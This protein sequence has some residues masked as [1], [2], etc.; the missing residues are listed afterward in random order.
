MNTIDHGFN[1]NPV[2]AD[3]DESSRGLEILA[4]SGDNHVYA[5]RVDGTPV[6]GWPVFLRDPSKVASVNPQTHKLVYAG[7]ADAY[8]GSKVLVSPSVGDVD[9]DGDLEVVAAVNEEYAEEP[10]ASRAR[11]QMGPILGAITDVGN[12]RVYVI[13]AKGSDAGPSTTPNHPNEQAFLPGWPASI[14]I[15]SARILPYVGEGPDGAPT[16]AD[17]DGNGDLEIGVATVAGPGYLLDHDGESFYGN[18][19]EGKDITFATAPEEFKGNPTDGPAFV[20]VGG[21]TFGELVPGVI[22]WAAPTGGLKRLLD[23]AFN[24]QQ[25]NA[26]D[27]V[28]AWDWDTGTFTPGF[29]SIVND[30]QF[31]STPSMADVSGDGVAEILE[32][33]AV[34]DARAISALEG[35]AS[36]WPKFTGGW[37]IASAGTGDLDGDQ[38]LDVAMVTREGWLFVWGTEGD[39]C[40]GIEWPKYQHD[41]GNT[42]NHETAVLN[43]ASC[44]PQPGDTTAQTL[45]LTP[46]QS[47]DPVG[48]PRTFTAEVKDDEGN[49]IEG[50]AVNW[51]EQGAGQIAE[52]DAT[53]DANGQA[54]AQVTST[55]RGNQTITAS[56]S[57]CAPTGDCSDTSLQRWGT[58]GC[59][60]YGTEGN[61]TLTGTSAGETIC[62]FGGKDTIL[63][64]G[65]NDHV[66][67][68]QGKDSI[69]GGPGLDAIRGGSGPDDLRGGKGGDRFHGS[70]GSDD[71]AGNGGSDVLVGSGGH[72][73][74][75]GGSGE[76][77][78]RGRSGNDDISGNAQN[79]YLRGS[80]GNDALNGGSG[81]DDCNARP[82]KNDSQKHCEI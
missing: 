47:S 49:P 44:L 37:S 20:A 67:G 1:H 70:A 9:N 18:D 38:L 57:P 62:G 39:A 80:K 51:S 4:G 19:P 68:H 5:W 17:V 16:L 48:T 63:A 35:S 60:I 52:S 15:L 25:L 82:G 74:L 73:S 56:T 30:L 12:G 78:L 40:Q 6:P 65:G 43:P 53:T 14:A 41:L 71:V 64:K 58:Q 45:E 46:D 21:G 72:D 54:E 33:T 11:E 13:D 55:Q 81:T 23:I 61:D 31:F 36:G 42:G 22:S 75:I 7:G 50:A 26:E 34:Y 76:D 32:G 29:P 2:I 24:S 69:K 77:T 27:Q 59:D 10:N 8:P 79:D 28:S 66:R 3:I